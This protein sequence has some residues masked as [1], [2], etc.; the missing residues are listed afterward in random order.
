MPL[1]RSCRHLNKSLS[2][3]LLS[4]FWRESTVRCMSH[5]ILFSIPF[6]YLVSR[7]NCSTCA[8]IRATS[9]IGL[10][11]VGARGRVPKHAVR[12]EGFRQDEALLAPL[13]RAAEGR[14]C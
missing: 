11:A 4:A 10:L 3:P 1:A 6:I 14:C 13:L 5:C 12:G 2:F 8:R 7:R 9:W